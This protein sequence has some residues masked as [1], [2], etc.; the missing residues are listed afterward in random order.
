MPISSCL[1]A[2]RYFLKDKSDIEKK[3]IY[4]RWL[5]DLLYSVY[6]IPNDSQVV[7]F[8]FFRSLVRDDY[9]LF[10]HDV[11][12]TLDDSSYLIIEDYSQLSDNISEEA[13]YYLNYLQK[14]KPLIDV[15]SELDRE[16]L[17]IRLCKYFIILSRV[18]TVKSK[19]VVFFADMQPVEHLIA[20]FM[21]DKGVKTATLQHGL[22]VDYG[23]I[24]TVNVINYKHHPSEY[25]L[26][27]GQCTADLINSYHN[28]SKQI[29]CGKPR[30]SIETKDINEGDYITVILDQVLFDKQNIQLLEI[31]EK[32]SLIKNKRLNIRF[33]PSKI[34]KKYEWLPDEYLSDCSLESSEFI[35]GHTTSMIHECLV[36]GIKAYRY[37]TQVP[38]IRLSTNLEFESLEQL[39]EIHE[40]KKSIQFDTSYYISCF[41]QESR[42]QY[43]KALLKVLSEAKLSKPLNG[44]VIDHWV[45][46]ILAQQTTQLNSRQPADDLSYLEM[47]SKNNLFPEKKIQKKKVTVVT[48]CH[49]DIENIEKTVLSVISQNFDDFEYIVVDRGSSDGTLECIKKYKANIDIILSESELGFYDVMNKSIAAANSDWSIF[50][51]AGDSFVDYKVLSEIFSKDLSNASFIYGDHNFS[52][53]QKNASNN[54]RPFSRVWQHPDFCYAVLFAKTSLLNDENFDLSKS[55]LAGYDFF[56]RCYTKGHVFKYVSR[57]I[58]VLSSTSN[59]SLTKERWAIVRDH[60]PSFKKNIIYYFLFLLDISGLRK[61]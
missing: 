6:Q 36:A 1:F 48:I 59:F 52:D 47:M 44:D 60:S 39:V 13:I 55:E 23:Q 21:R 17:Y 5:I 33:H 14:I 20:L 58:A 45:E 24:D 53:R 12:S 16:C 4:K 38:A 11:I 56:F 54:E 18:L 46:S 2:D 8:L 25:F 42:D 51:N 49:N 34:A 43:K 9:K 28:S 31:A 61:N 19:C 40:R 26:A 22:Y 30:I 29:V 41:G 35:L 10:F 32:F 15:D 27:W 3:Q 7:D 57:Q 50:M 37:K